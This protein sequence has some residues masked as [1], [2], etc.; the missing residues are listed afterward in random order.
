[1]CYKRATYRT[2]LDKR[3]FR[4]RLLTLIKNEGLQYG[5]Y[6]VDYGGSKLADTIIRQLIY[7]AE[8]F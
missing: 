4:Q 1:M 2:K 8:D 7:T 5:D 6:I 3:R